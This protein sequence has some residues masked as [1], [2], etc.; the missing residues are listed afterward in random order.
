M[1][2]ETKIC[3]KCGIEKPINEY[4]KS[5]KYFRGE[6]KACEKESRKK[7]RENNKEHIREYAKQY[8]EINGEKIKQTNKIWREKNIDK[9]KEY[10][11]N[12]RLK[13]NEQARK[14]AKNNREK[15]NAY[16]RK[17]YIKNK[18]KFK[19]I[20]SKNYEKFKE[21]IKERSK[22]YRDEHKE[23]YK[24]YMKKYNDDNKEMLKSKN[25]ERV[26]K[27]R[28]EDET[29]KTKENIKCLIRNSFRKKGY[30]KSSH[31]EKILGCNLN[32]LYNYL[33]QTFKNNYGYEW[34]KKE[35]VHIDH[36]IPLAT[37][38]TKEEI[39]RL[40]HYTNL[41]LLKVKDNLQKKDK[42]DW[43]LNIKV[44]GEEEAKKELAL[45][46]EEDNL[47]ISNMEVGV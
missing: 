44:V 16:K 10:E 30:C 8:K 35:P 36:I 43:K 32:Y 24:D 39:V 1:I 40:N 26:K 21:K 33:L 45:V 3:S 9:I 6:C 42:L 27:R 23:K 34:N 47:Q 37:A 46:N 14:W 38:K 41:Q 19:N 15:I 31:T 29:Y 13:R 7:W 18:E 4:R 28:K 22:K 17:N 11:K 5:G 20:S 12:N 2:K 25:N